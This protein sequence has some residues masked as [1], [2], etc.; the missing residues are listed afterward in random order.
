[1]DVVNGSVVERTQHELRPVLR[2]GLGMPCHLLYQCSASSCRW[3]EG[4]GKG[5]NCK[6]RVLRFAEDASRARSL[7]QQHNNS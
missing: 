6:W 2:K 1:M 3:T 5:V 4:K 7:S